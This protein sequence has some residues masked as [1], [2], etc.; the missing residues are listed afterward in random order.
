MTVYAHITFRGPLDINRKKTIP[1]KKRGQ[2]APEYRSYTKELLDSQD[3]DTK[4]DWD[5][6]QHIDFELSSMES[7]KPIGSSLCKTT[8]SNKNN[9]RS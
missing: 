2:D 3:K 4:V 1:K 8:Y 5:S 9:S 7:M 6:L